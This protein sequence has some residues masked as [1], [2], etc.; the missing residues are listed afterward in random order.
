MKNPLMQRW[1][2]F[3]YRSGATTSLSNILAVYSDI[4]TSY[5]APGRH[6]HT[7]SHIADM[8]HNLD[9]YFPNR[10]PAVELAIWFHDY[11]YYPGSRY[12]ELD[13]ALAMTNL[14]S[15]AVDYGSRIFPGALVQS[16]REHIVATKKH[17][18]QGNQD[19]AIVCDLDLASLAETQER[20]RFNTTLIRMEYAG[21]SDTQW[22]IDRLRFIGT[23]LAR[24][25]YQTGEC[26]TQL[27]DSAKRNLSMERLAY[28]GVQN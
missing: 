2:D 10:S 9:I 16:A 1:I 3:A 23:F 4:T 27:E 22:S 17:D 18:A 19:S 20:Y 8:L 12:N 25:I 24:D 21:F 7:L 14:F 6:Y 26:K 5:T 15:G 11:I 28:I 13:S